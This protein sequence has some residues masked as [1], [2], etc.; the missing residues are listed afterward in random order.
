MTT[1]ELNEALT[2]GAKI[3]ETMNELEHAIYCACSSVPCGELI[4][5]YVDIVASTSQDMNAHAVRARV[6]D[7]LT[8][9][10]DR[11]GKSQDFRDACLRLSNRF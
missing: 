10:W 4:R 6:F 11:A 5:N 3:A 2:M 7:T 8:K 9:L 1:R